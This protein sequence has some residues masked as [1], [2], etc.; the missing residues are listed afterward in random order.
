VNLQS[1]WTKWC[2]TVGMLMLGAWGPVIAADGQRNDPLSV[3]GTDL[4]GDIAV[5][6]GEAAAAAQDFKAEVIDRQNHVIALGPTGSLELK[7]ISGDI[8]CVAGS[9]SNVTVEVVRHARGRTD[10][11]ARIG[12]T[13]VSA[14]IDHQGERATVAAAYP[15]NRRQPPY[16][17]TV[18]YIVTA[19]AGTRVSASSV[20][21]DVTIRSIKGDIS[22]GSVSGDVS[23][24][25]AA[26]VS[27]A[28]SVSGNVSLVGLGTSSAVRVG[29]VSGDVSFESVKA[30]QISAESV[31]GSIRFTNGLATGIAFKTVSGAIEYEGGIGQGGRYDVQ[32]HSGDVRVSVGRGVGFELQATTFSG[33]IR[34]EPPTALRAATSTSRSVRGTIGDGSAV[35]AATTFSGDITVVTR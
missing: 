14:V 2:A 5:W 22:A 23:I 26:H 1:T 8:S 19:P 35:I 12:L 4:A 17:V 20:S 11:D 10:A 27:T 15:S 28:K 24:A 16:S 25:N 33:S 6:A 34:T 7:T 29:S 18:S 3:A 13:E 31:S 21:G 9:G 30:Q 32:S